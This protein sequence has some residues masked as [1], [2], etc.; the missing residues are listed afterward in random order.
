VL[1]DRAEGLEIHLIGVPAAAGRVRA[2]GVSNFTPGNLADLILKMGCF[3]PFFGNND[4]SL[5]SLDGRGGGQPLGR[6]P[7]ARHAAHYR[8]P[9]D[10]RSGRAPQDPAAETLKPQD[11]S[12]R[13]R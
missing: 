5:D 7:P 12:G 8:Q 11:Q 1:N 10:F 6:C 9:E 13:C 3:L 4:G 2:I